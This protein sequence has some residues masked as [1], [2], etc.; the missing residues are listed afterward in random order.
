LPALAM[1]GAAGIDQ[2]AT[3]L[4]WR[5][6][7]LALST[8]LLAYLAIVLIAIHPYYLDYFAE[9]VGGTG[10][11][12]A[13]GTF[14]T[15][16]WGE[17]VDRAVA[18]VNDHAAPAAAVDRDCIEPVHLAWF[19][20]DLW[21]SLTHSPGEAAWI[22]RYAPASHP[23]PVPPDARRVFEVTADDAVL[24]EVYERA[25]AAVDGEH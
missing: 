3:W 23:C 9:Q 22:I 4:R 18:Y 21:P 12:A 1:I 20:A 5:A 25:D 7:F 8:A 16:W 6:V 14:E 2:L 15:A 10:R 11:V 17:G 13:H 24:A 19:R